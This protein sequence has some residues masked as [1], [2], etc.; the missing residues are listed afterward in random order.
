[1]P[2]SPKLTSGSLTTLRLRKNEERR[3]SIGHDWI[4]SNEVD[5]GNTPLKGFTP[6]QQVQVESSRGDVLGMAYVNPHSLISGRLFS[7]HAGEVLDTA[8]LE[9][10]R[11]SCRARVCP[12]V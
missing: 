1:M 11:A 7:R 5:T 10:G 6:G 12:Y 2:E 4:Y 8:L 3:I 9:I